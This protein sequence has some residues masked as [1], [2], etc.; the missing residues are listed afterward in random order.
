MNLDDIL[1][2]TSIARNVINLDKEIEE[3]LGII[4][5]NHPIIYREVNRFCKR[6]PEIVK[7][8]MFLTSRYYKSGTFE[9]YEIVKDFF[10]IHFGSY[11]KIIRILNS[12]F[13]HKTK[14]PKLFDKNRIRNS[15]TANNMHISEI[16]RFIG[17]GLLYLLNNHP[18]LYFKVAEHPLRVVAV[19]GYVLAYVMEKGSLPHSGYIKKLFQLR[20]NISTRR[21]YRR[22]RPIL[23]EFLNNEEDIEYLKNI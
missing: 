21:L 5:E 14:Q 3:G 16:G 11:S 23:L 9:R 1:E 20:S 12:T 17:K 19:T 4:L 7:A 18:D 2:G 8:A 13:N 10:D 22:L 6:N 15:E